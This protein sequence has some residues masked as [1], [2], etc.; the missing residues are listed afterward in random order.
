MA[1]RSRG[2]RRLNVRLILAGVLVFA[3][4][5]GAGLFVQTVNRTYT[6]AIAARQADRTV[7]ELPLRKASTVKGGCQ[8]PV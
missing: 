3:A 7:A 5:V 8:L 6:A 1:M 2:G 4:L